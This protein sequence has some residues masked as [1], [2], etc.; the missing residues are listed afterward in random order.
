MVESCQ[1]KDHAKFATT[2]DAPVYPKEE[3][4]EEHTGQSFQHAATRDAQTKHK[5]ETAALI[6]GQSIQLAAME[7]V[8]IFP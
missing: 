3:G 4:F 1:G 5:Q 2:K 8:P 7:D 6:T